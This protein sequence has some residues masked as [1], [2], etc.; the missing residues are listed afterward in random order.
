MKSSVGCLAGSR[1]F[2]IKSRVLPRETRALGSHTGPP[3]VI[4]S[5]DPNSITDRFI[6]ADSL[7]LLLFLISILTIRPISMFSLFLVSRRFTSTPSPYMKRSTPSP[8]TS[9]SIADGRMPIT[10][11]LMD[12][13]AALHTDKTEKHLSHRRRH[14][15]KIKKKKREKE[16][17]KRNDDDETRCWSTATESTDHVARRWLTALLQLDDDNT[18]NQHQK[19][20]YLEREN[21]RQIGRGG[22]WSNHD[23][24]N[25]D[26]TYRKRSSQEKST[27]PTA[28]MNGTFLSF[29]LSFLS[30]TFYHTVS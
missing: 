6:I 14:N 23:G 13:R 10:A 12:S 22:E 2:N 19:T 3:R 5:R 15:N 4:V 16:K 20:V 30:F 26:S 8:S 24:R 7:L 11:R 25:T 1:L 29:F 18:P 9:Q 28:L 17:Q 21:A 27:D